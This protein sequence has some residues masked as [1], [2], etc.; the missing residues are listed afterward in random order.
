MRQELIDHFFCL[1]EMCPDFLRDVRLHRV[2]CQSLG[3]RAAGN[4]YAGYRHAA[5]RDIERV[6]W[7]RVYDLIIRLWP[8]FDQSGLGQMY[9]DGVNRILA[10]H[11]VAWDLGE[12]GRLHR[13]LPVEAA[14]QVSAAFGELQ[15]SQYAAALALFNAARDAF[16]DR[17]RPDRDACSNIFDAM[18]SVA[19]EKYG[20]PNASLNQI[21]VAM[22]SIARYANGIGG[23]RG[24]W[25]IRQ[26]R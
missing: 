26:P 21:P 5:G 18:E 22:P 4:P 10:A 3:M 7:P 19:K 6:P 13:V 2:I 17:P 9:R 24:S 1:A 25:K 8:E 11:G 12:D 20:L 23:C 14:A 15:G 16:D